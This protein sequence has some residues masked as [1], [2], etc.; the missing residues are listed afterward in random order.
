MSHLH[1]L[2]LLA[3]SLFVLLAGPGYGLGHPSVSITIHHR[4]RLDIRKMS[5]VVFWGIENYETNRCGEELAERLTK[6]LSETGFAVVSRHE[7]NRMLAE[8]NLQGTGLTDPMLIAKDLAK[9]YPTG[10]LVFGKIDRPC[11]FVTEPHNMNFLG[12]NTV[13]AQVTVSAPIAIVDLKTTKLTTMAVKGVGQSE[14]GAFLGKKAAPDTNLAL[15][16][17]YES[18]VSH[19]L[20]EFSDWDE[21]LSLI[22]YDDNK[23]NLREGANS[24]L[25]HQNEQAILTIRA[26]LNEYGTN[27][28]DKKML[29]KAYYNLGVAEICAGH[30]NE[31][32]IHLRSSLSFNDSPE[33]RETYLIAGKLIA[34]ASTSDETV[35]ELSTPS[36]IDAGLSPVAPVSENSESKSHPAHQE[37]VSS[38]MLQGTMDNESVIKMA[39]LTLLDDVIIETI[40]RAPG[41][42]FDL[43]ANG[44]IALKIAGVSNDVILNM[45]KVSNSRKTWVCS[46]CGRVF[47]TLPDG[48][49]C[50]YD[51]TPLTEKPMN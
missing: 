29:A 14:T 32:S 13:M 18:V 26:S 27:S 5:P 39:Q 4:A 44:L 6:A 9:I 43:S 46:K 15:A 25:N 7:L 16:Q 48:G 21:T 45:Q 38:E 8:R 28:T 23:W 22:V 49:R 40:K 42:N 3:C 17:A 11:E 33:A 1:R 31:A 41:T 10:V 51:G 19:F 47:R 37:A 36:H 35:G 20:A 24:I 2:I 34:L 50:T 12:L 30:F